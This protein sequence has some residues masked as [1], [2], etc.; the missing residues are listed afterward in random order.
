MMRK[1][2]THIPNRQ[3]RSIIKYRI[4]LC[5][6]SVVYLT[7]L[8]YKLTGFWCR[9]YGR[10]PMKEAVARTIKCACKGDIVNA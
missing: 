6:D 5:G 10:I 4:N 2:I 7:P 3:I 9:N 1:R 8:G